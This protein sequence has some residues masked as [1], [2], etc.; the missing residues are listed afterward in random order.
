MVGGVMQARKLQHMCTLHVR[1]RADNEASNAAVFG[2]PVEAAILEF[3]V[4]AVVPIFRLSSS[5]PKRRKDTILNAQGLD[6]AHNNFL[7]HMPYSGEK[8]QKEN[9]IHKFDVFAPLENILPH[10]EGLIF[11]WDCFPFSLLVYCK[12]GHL[13]SYYTK[14]SFTKLL[15]ITLKKRK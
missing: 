6:I 11:Y 7:C 1:K 14:L 8:K 13:T 4:C 5:K 15:Y 2:T 10:W 12:C 3:L 9:A